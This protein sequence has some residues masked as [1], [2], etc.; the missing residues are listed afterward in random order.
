MSLN[1][2]DY[3][4]GRELYYADL[5][6]TALIVA[7][8]SKADDENARKLRA[9]W[10]EICETTQ[11]RYWAPAAVLDTEV[12]HTAEKIDELLEYAKRAG[13]V[14]RGYLSGVRSDKA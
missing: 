10:P 5:P 1:L 14:A 12:P 2:I 9:A 7:A 11:K 3:L 4:V 6:F 8:I 13:R